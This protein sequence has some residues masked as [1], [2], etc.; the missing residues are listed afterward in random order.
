MDSALRVRLAA[1]GQRE[2]FGHALEEEL[3]TEAA[4][5]LEVLIGGKG[6]QPGRKMLVGFEERQFLNC[7]CV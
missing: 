1:G 7:K 2:F 3:F 4:E 6:L 5:V